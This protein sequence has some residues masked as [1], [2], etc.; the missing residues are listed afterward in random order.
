[1]EDCGQLQLYIVTVAAALTV[2]PFALS[3]VSGIEIALSLVP[4]MLRL[5]HVQ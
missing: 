2:I 5:R 1:M 4:G 3:P